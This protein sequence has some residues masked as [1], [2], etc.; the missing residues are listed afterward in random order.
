MTG[1]PLPVTYF[2]DAQSAQSSQ[3][4]YHTNSLPTKKYHN[5]CATSHTGPVTTAQRSLVRNQDPV[6][7][8]QSRPIRSV[9]RGGGPKT[10]AYPLLIISTPIQAM[11]HHPQQQQQQPM[12]QEEAHM[13]AKRQGSIGFKDVAL[14]NKIRFQPGQETGI[15]LVGCG[16]G[17]LAIAAYKVLKCLTPGPFDIAN[18]ANIV[19]IDHC[20][21]LLDLADGVLAD[22]A[23]RDQNV[24]SVVQ[25]HRMDAFGFGDQANIDMI[26]GSF[27][28][29]ISTIVVMDV[30]DNIDDPATFE[31]IRSLISLLRIGGRIF[32][33][34]CYQPRCWSA[35][36]FVKG[37]AIPP[38]LVGIMNLATPRF[39]QVAEQDVRNSCHYILEPRIVDLEC[40][41]LGKVW[42]EFA[43]HV[44]ARSD[45]GVHIN[46]E[47]TFY[48]QPNIFHN[49][50]TPHIKYADS[51]ATYCI[52]AL[53]DLMRAVPMDQSRYDIQEEMLDT[54]RGGR[55]LHN[56]Q[57]LFRDW[58]PEFFD[59]NNDAVG[60]HL[61][62]ADIITRYC[63]AIVEPRQLPDWDAFY[64]SPASVLVSLRRR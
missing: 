6:T 34:V 22:E 51:S 2:A 36:H 53:E 40:M 3:Y 24:R 56:L 30:F 32:F 17:T 38:N 64:L 4:N 42:A 26:L 12:T 10:Q 13:W 46:D 54:I 21:P 47:A 1:V 43:G 59:S 7:T 31:A 52:K 62:V 45:S 29:G 8:Q 9:T 39:M 25:F 5:I 14:L 37:H 50:A 41:W 55:S 28:R 18:I 15:F 16:L 11:A 49:T 23:S 58:K 33:N 48:H 19:G 44:G 60:T 35:A 61:V 57:R 63:A 27:P 20:H